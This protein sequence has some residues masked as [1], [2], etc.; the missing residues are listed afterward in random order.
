MFMEL[1]VDNKHQQF[2][3][4]TMLS[5]EQE[6]INSD[7]NKFPVKEVFRILKS[8]IETEENSVPL[9]LQL[10]DEFMKKFVKGIYVGKNLHWTLKRAYARL[11]PQR[12]L[13]IK[14]KMNHATFQKHINEMLS[15]GYL[16]RA[17]SN[18]YVR[19][20]LI[21]NKI[22]IL[23]NKVLKEGII[24][25]ELYENNVFIV[26]FMERVSNDVVYM[27]K[28]CPICKKEVIPKINLS[29]TMETADTKYKIIWK[30]NRHFNHS[31]NEDTT[32]LVGTSTVNRLL[33]YY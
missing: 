26:E 8:I 13:E 10:S 23:T 1:K 27:K 33:F 25:E 18:K 2:I 17:Y 28:I 14:S 4:D 7:V 19:N 9:A 12:E 15:S 16:L 21:L 32:G 31:V 24:P 11:I 3:I 5:I 6:H 30:C 20:Y 22:K 29:L